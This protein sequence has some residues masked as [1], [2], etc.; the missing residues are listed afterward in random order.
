LL[1]KVGLPGFEP[2]SPV[3]LRSSISDATTQDWSPDQVRL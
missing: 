2:G 3:N 1:H